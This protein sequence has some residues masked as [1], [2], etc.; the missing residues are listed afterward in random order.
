MAE[1]FRARRIF[2]RAKFLIRQGAEMRKLLFVYLALLTAG[3]TAGCTRLLDGAQCPCVEGFSCCEAQN[4]CVPE[5]SACSE[6]AADGASQL[7]ST[8]E[9]TSKGDAAAADRVELLCSNGRMC[10]GGPFDYVRL[11]P[12]EEAK[13]LIGRWQLCSGSG[14]R[15]GPGNPVLGIEFTREGTYHILGVDARGALTRVYGL[16]STG[17]YESTEDGYV[18]IHFQGDDIG[19]IFGPSFDAARNHMY[20]Y[21][22][23]EVS[24]TPW[25]PRLPQVNASYVRVPE[26]ADGV[27]GTCIPNYRS[28]IPDGAVIPDSA[29]ISDAGASSC[30]YARVCVG[31]P[32]AFA[33]L[34]NEDST[35]QA[36]LGRWQVCEGQGFG[37]GPDYAQEGIEFT[38]DGRFR[39]LRVDEDAALVPA[40]GLECSGDYTVSQEG[41]LYFRFSEG[42]VNSVFPSFDA[43]GTH[44]HVERASG[45]KLNL[46]R[47]APAE[48]AAA[49]DCGPNDGGTALP[50][51]AVCA[52]GSSVCPGAPFAFAALAARTGEAMLGR[53]QICAGYV[54][55]WPVNAGAG[56]EFTSDGRFHLL[57][58]NA[59]GA[60][61]RVVGLYATGTYQRSLDD[62][63]VTLSFPERWFVRELSLFFDG[64]MAHMRAEAPND[65]EF[66]QSSA[67][68]VRIA[69]DQ[70]LVPGTCA[71]PGPWDA[72]TGIPGL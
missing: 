55:W 52:S 48:Q 50:S 16:N 70:D 57:G 54:P 28:G 26:G 59:E 2:L 25:I 60:V 20:A 49:V 61:T 43:Q 67:E 15:W 47:V 12:A 19:S 42:G 34:E 69:T 13:A 10:P 32:F 37:F 38:D 71:E 27:P 63:L 68:Y 46:V 35:R 30:P 8:L 53:W 65:T 18:S 44:L 36:L 31:A 45:T 14:F 9:G 7:D 66:M 33:K 3:I 39:L 4:V 17:T 41:D 6:P 21:E 40:S 56:I 22:D 24:L 51:G 29:A 64:P 72:G 62:H 23:D 11:A 58:K 1:L 5:G